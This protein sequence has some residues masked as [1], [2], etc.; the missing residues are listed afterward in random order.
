MIKIRSMDGS[1]FQY[2]IDAIKGI[3]EK[4]ADL[5]LFDDEALTF[6]IKKTGG[7]LRDLFHC[8]TKTASRAENRQAAKIE[9]EDAKSATIQLRSLLTRQIETK[10]Y[11][12]LKNIYRGGKYKN[13]I[14]DKAM[15]LEM[16][17]GLIVL[18]YNGDRWH[19]LHPLIEDFLKEQGE[20]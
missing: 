16:M 12:L 3:V 15:L 19:D 18:E 17:Q 11:P 10:N 2:G 14:E 7:I 4:R 20:L 9:L 8:I 13:Q 6:L 5:S 1:S